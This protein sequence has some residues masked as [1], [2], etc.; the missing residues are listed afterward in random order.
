MSLEEMA[1][2]GVVGEIGDVL[3]VD[4]PSW[5]ESEGTDRRRLES[6]ERW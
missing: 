6:R 3:L 1:D 4:I 5:D 2:R